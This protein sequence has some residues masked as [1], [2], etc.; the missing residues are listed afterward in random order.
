[1]T[2]ANFSVQRDNTVQRA[3]P[4]D[5]QATQSRAGRSHSFSPAPQFNQQ[6]LLLLIQL[7][8][9]I[10]QNISQP[11]PEPQPLQLNQSQQDNLKQ[12]LGINPNAPFNVQ[13]LDNDGNGTLSAGDTAVVNGGITNGE[14]QRKTLTDADIAQI[15][16][17]KGNVPADFSTNLQKWQSSAASDPQA[18]I[19]YTTQQSCFCPSEFT[20]PM[21][22][23][24]S[25]GQISS[26][27]YAD[28]GEAVPDNIKQSLKTIDQRFDEL[29]NAYENGAAQVDVTYDNDRGFPTS[30][31]IDQDRR[32]ADEEISYNITNLA[33][34]LP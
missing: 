22:I 9:F 12:L 10:L 29:R 28:T 3:N 27:T 33:I 34:A 31:F 21:N 23:I 17:P 16:T 26:A 20:R 25:N 30:V 19:F 11:R 13:V 7:I 1:M 5:N 2:P 8:Q 18:S 14:I 6:L 24:E 15:N 32:L 4:Q